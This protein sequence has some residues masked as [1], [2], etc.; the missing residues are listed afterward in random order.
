MDSY[1]VPAV[2]SCAGGHGLV[3]AGSTG[4]RSTTAC[5]GCTDTGMY[6]SGNANAANDQAGHVG[7]CGR[8]IVDWQLLTPEVGFGPGQTCRRSLERWQQAGR[9]STG[10]TVFCSPS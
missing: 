4:L 7:V 6:P 3:A 5:T 1:H 8:Q 10:C 9:A 2:V